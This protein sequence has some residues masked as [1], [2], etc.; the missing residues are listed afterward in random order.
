MMKL[1]T[2]ITLAAAALAG[3]AAAQDYP[4]RPVRIINPFPAGGSSD[5]LARL[6]A[7]GL[8]ERLGQQF[9]VENR[10]GAAGN[11][12]TDAV[13]KAAPDGYTLGVSTSGPLANNKLLYKAMPYDP[14]KAFAPIMLIG[15]IPLV[16]AANPQVPART[17]KEFVELARAQPGKQSVGHPGNGTIGHL[18]LELVKSVTRT[19]MLGVAYKGDIPAMTE[20]L[21]G[22]IQATS[23]PVSAFIA[24]IQAGKLNALALTSKSRFPG[25]PNV[26]TAQEQGFDIEATVWSAM[27]APAGTP[28]AVIERLNQEANRIIASPEGRARLAQFG[29]IAIGGPP[30][31]L[32][33]QIAGDTAK[34]RR[35]IEAAKISIE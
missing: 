16:I 2:W 22:S 26:P 17:L 10:A 33:S 34:W 11:L 32:A 6:I 29:A 3:P 27:V 9:V 20:L 19:D 30:E 24:N 7:Q 28:R 13:A 4:T 18:A 35:V 5:I 1:L 31:R 23:A 15:E 25:L 14:E 8:S 12:G 21:G